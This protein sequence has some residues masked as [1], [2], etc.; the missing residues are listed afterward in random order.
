MEINEER[1]EEFMG[2]MV[3]HMMGAT[4]LACMILGHKAGLYSAMFGAG[5]L[6]VDQLAAAA[7]TN[8]RLTQEWINQQASVGG[9]SYDPAAGTYEMSN[10]AGMALAVP[11]SPV[12]LAGGLDG[13]RAMFMDMDTVVDAMK[14]DGGVAWGDHH[15]CMYD[16]VAEFFRPAY[17]HNLSQVWIPAMSDGG[18]R[19]QGG[20]IADIGCGTGAA[21]CH[22]AG[23][24]PDAE[25]TGFDYHSPSV[26]AA[27]ERASSQGVGNVSF[28]AAGSKDFEGNFDV[29]CFFDA[30]HDMG[31]PV[32]IAQHAKNQLAEGGSVLLV[33]PFALDS[34][35]ANHAALGGVFY[36]ASTFLCTPCSLS[37]EVGRGMG[38][39]S[40]EPGMQAVFSEAGYSSLQRVSE[41]PFHI[42]YEATP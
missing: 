40:G 12:W 34:F 42:V 7:G 10:E 32:G 26:D 37:Q 29:I 28:E 14:G 35:E 27:R 4:T 21:A 22:I 41:T 8:P 6:T 39:Q 11:E 13:L 2:G 25:V 24:F 5:P 19:F 33:E 20:R 38:A 15:H 31:D 17:E 1:L 9:V 36:G 3:G 30:L 16:G 23:A 18:A